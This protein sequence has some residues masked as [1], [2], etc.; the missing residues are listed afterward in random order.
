MQPLPRRHRLHVVYDAGSWAGL[1]ACQRRQ[2]PDNGLDV[3]QGRHSKREQL[4]GVRRRQGVRGGAVV[5]RDVPYDD[6]ER[7][8]LQLGLAFLFCKLL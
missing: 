1:Y 3:R 8:Q 7:P 6:D 4:R 2:L 5:V